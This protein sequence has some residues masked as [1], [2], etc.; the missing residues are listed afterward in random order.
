MTGLR[1]RPTPRDERGS[2]TVLTL[3]MAMVILLGMALLSNAASVFIQRRE[4]VAAADGMAL[5]GA[6]AIDVD[7]I[8]RHGTASVLPVQRAGAPRAARAHATQ[9]GYRTS[10]PGFRVSSIRVSAQTV[11][12]TVAARVRVPFRV[13]W[14]ARSLGIQAVS[15]ARTSIR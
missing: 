11:T 12:V 1:L 8:Y 3:G 10:I 5:A 14:P 2:I 6:Q 9:S 15:R 7:A 4:L 13:L